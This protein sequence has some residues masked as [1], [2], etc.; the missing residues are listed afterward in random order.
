M[1]KRKIK[2]EKD[3][4]KPNSNQTPTSPTYSPYKPQK[5]EESVSDQT[6]D[7]VE[8]NFDNH[9]YTK[10][11]YINLL[12][13]NNQG[14]NNLKPKP[15]Y[16]QDY[17]SLNEVA[18][19]SEIHKNTYEESEYQNIDRIDQGEYEY[20]EYD[21]QSESDDDNVNYEYASEGDTSDYIIIVMWIL[22]KAMMRSKRMMT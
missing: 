12:D 19:G 8:D 20:Y 7:L 17:Y 13:Y 9:R 2:L 18:L 3:W 6:S 11:D 14:K 5:S 4:K 10:D 22:R 21:Y 1:G 15:N 16:D